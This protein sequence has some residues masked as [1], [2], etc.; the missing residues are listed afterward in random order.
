[1]LDYPSV[2]VVTLDPTLVSESLLL[3][4]GMQ[5]GTPS[6][7]PMVVAPDGLPKSFHKNGISTSPGPP[8]HQADLTGTDLDHSGSVH[9]EAVANSLV[10]TDPSSWVQ[11]SQAQSKR[12]L[13]IL[14]QGT[15]KGHGGLPYI[16]T[17]MWGG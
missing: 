10:K 13:I 8:E 11:Q 15:F 2:S 14:N 5:V 1:M 3:D 6:G 9:L 16:R 12:H 4:R 7:I 17:S